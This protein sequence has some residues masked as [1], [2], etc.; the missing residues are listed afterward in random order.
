MRSFS[1]KYCNGWIIVDFKTG[2]ET[3]EKNIKYQEQLDFYKNVVEK[4]GY[5]VLDARLLWL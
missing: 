5:K 2:K 1:F 3:D 4:L